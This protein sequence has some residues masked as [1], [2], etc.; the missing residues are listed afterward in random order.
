MATLQSS[1]VQGTLTVDNALTANDN[2]V[3]NGNLS[4]SSG[5]QLTVPDG[6]AAPYVVERIG[7]SPGDDRP[8]YLIIGNQ[9]G[10]G[11]P[12]CGGTLYGARRSGNSA[13]A[14]IDLHV[15]SRSSNRGTTSSIFVRSN[16]ESASN[17][18]LRNVD[19]QGV[20][21]LALQMNL[22][23]QFFLFNA[24]G[25]YWKGFKSSGIDFIFVGAS[26]VSNVANASQASNQTFHMSAAFSAP[27]KNFLID[28]PLGNNMQLRHGSIEAPR[29]DL[30]YRGDVQIING[31]ATVDIDQASSMTPGTFGSLTK[32][33]SVSALENQTGF[34]RL[35]PSPIVNGKFEIQAESSDCNDLVHWTVMAERKDIDPLVVEETLNSYGLDGDDE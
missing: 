22:S 3:I 9:N 10:S 21:K 35:K 24:T 6:V 31:R 28:H 25:L 26:Q 27:S 7:D 34:T 18:I 17:F 33:A 30:I 14:M 23:S 19:Y 8:H 15:S 2:T 13:S 1:N 11:S 32:F 12:R 29:Y 5:N 16:Q 4:V 20:R